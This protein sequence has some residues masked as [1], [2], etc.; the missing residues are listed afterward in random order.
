MGTW[1]SNDLPEEH[2]DVPDQ[3]T[4]WRIVSWIVWSVSP[5]LTG[6]TI[7]YLLLD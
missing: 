1:D 7:L 4:V 3:D 5:A 6:V 2:C